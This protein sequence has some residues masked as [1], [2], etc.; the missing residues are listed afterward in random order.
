MNEQ[1]NRAVSIL[2]NTAGNAVLV[3]LSWSFME[4]RRSNKSLVTGIATQHH[5]NESDISVTNRLLDKK[6]LKEIKSLRTKTL[7]FHKKNTLP[8]D[9]SGWRLLPAR[10][11]TKYRKFLLEAEEKLAFLKGDLDAS[12]DAMKLDAQVR[13]NGLYNEALFPTR[14]QVQ[15]SY[16]MTARYE[17]V[18]IPSQLY[19]STASTDL[20]NAMRNEMAR[21]IEANLLESHKAN[22]TRLAEALQHLLSRIQVPVKKVNVLGGSIAVQGEQL[23]FRNASVDAIK[24]LINAG[25]SMN[26]S[27]DPKFSAILQRLEK[28][29]LPDLSANTL[30]E[31]AEHREKVAS[32]LETEVSDIL[33][34]LPC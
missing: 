1:L 17:Q 9:D 14:E 10:N 27:N 2:T 20:N 18:S 16:S 23:H 32:V 21:D 31:S 25:E 26:F 5:A 15:D 3:R 22:F 30:R 33:A 34:N 19:L 6:F 29:L 12:Y 28:K 7:D 4:G 11:L 13:L 24:D 8:Y